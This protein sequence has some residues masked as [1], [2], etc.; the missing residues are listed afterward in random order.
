M[1][2]P[3]PFHVPVPLTF[4]IA[5]KGQG[6]VKATSHIPTRAPPIMLQL[7]FRIRTPQRRSHHL[8]NARILRRQRLRDRLQDFV[9]LVLRVRRRRET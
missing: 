2:E 4:P 6:K 7:H 9:D 8:K 3:S 1:R 5:C